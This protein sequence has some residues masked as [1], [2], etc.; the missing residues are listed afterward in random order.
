MTSCQRE[1]SFLHANK[2]NSY[3]SPL[4]YSSAPPSPLLSFGSFFWFFRTVHS[5]SSHL[6]PSSHYLSHR[7]SLL[8]I[9]LFIYFL[10]HFLLC[11]SLFSFA[12]FLLFSSLSFL[13]SSSSP[14]PHCFYSVFSSS[15]F[16]LICSLPFL[17]N[18]HFLAVLTFLI[19]PVQFCLR[20][21]VLLLLFF[22]L[23][24]LLLLL[25]FL[26]LL[27]LLLLI[28]LLL[29]LLLLLL[30]PLLL[31]L[32]LFPLLLLLLFLL[33]LLLLL[34]LLL[35]PNSLKFVLGFLWQ[36]VG[37]QLLVS[38]TDKTAV[39]FLKTD[40]LLF[41]VAKPCTVQKIILIYHYLMNV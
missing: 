16:I 7:I 12:L 2:Y 30:L 24:L 38:P 20:L 29:L 25:L 18:I 9:L 31:F 33:F 3:V 6:H 8:H 1:H 13:S 17:R 21:F 5:F 40:L 35:L 22:F 28:F 11:W 4:Q 27:L 37:S 19:R 10:I 41:Y 32:L 36:P 39:A 34:L 14:T 15:F 26:L 23:L